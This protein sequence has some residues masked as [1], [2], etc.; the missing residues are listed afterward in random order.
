MK[1]VGAQEAHDLLQSDPKLTYLDVRSVPE[2]EAGHAAGAINIP[3]LHFSPGA[4]MSPND[5]FQA[6]VEAT[7]DKNAKYVIGCKTGGR[8][9]R[10]CEVMTQ[11][12]FTDVTNMRGGF[13]GLTDNTGR[14]VEP[15]WSTLGL[16]TCAACDENASYEALAAKAKRV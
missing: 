16:P 6:V 4:G 3:L 13:G 10:A 12:G 1:E 2:F 5:D 7:L 14:L 9:A 8:S 15:G 11:M